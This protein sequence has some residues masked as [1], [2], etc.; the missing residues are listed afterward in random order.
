[1]AKILLDAAKEAEGII[2]SSA[3]SK[4]VGAAVERARMQQASRELR[5]AAES[6]WGTQITPTMK[7]GMEAAAVAAVNSETFVND[8]L[9]QALGARFQA[10]EDA[11]AFDAK[12]S[13][14]NLR[15]KAANTIPLSEQVYRSKALANGLVEKEI[16][17][18]IALRTS[19][20][21]LAD[22]V[23]HLISP[24]TAGGVSY[25]ANR[26]ART[27]I[28]NAFHHAQI[29]RRADEP[30]TEGMKW[31]LSG[32]HPKPDQCNEY[33]EKSHFKNGDTGVFRPSEV[34]G[35]PHPNCLCYLT[36][37]TVGEDEFINNFLKGDYNA[38]I[39]QEIYRSGIGTVC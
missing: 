8:V 13:V 38:Y 4:G 26:L 9:Q 19:A 30:W 6:M 23:R 25:A 17:R 37:V 39:E 5:K 20:K 33:A 14:D 15:A 28:N 18:A 10:L 12:N 34:P 22:R 24:N 31:N 32:S 27:E 11:F 7:K 3:G 35:K 21:Q 2:V 16:Q 36:T 1:M 29:A